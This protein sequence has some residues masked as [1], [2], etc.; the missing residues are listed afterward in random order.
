MVFIKF[1]LNLGFILL[2]SLNFKN[3]WFCKLLLYP[4]DEAWVVEGG[5]GG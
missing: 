3:V 2:R 1:C 4:C 5:V